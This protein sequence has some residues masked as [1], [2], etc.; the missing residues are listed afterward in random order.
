MQTKFEKDLKRRTWGGD[1]IS[2]KDV[3][4]AKNKA[5]KEILKE[6]AEERLEQGDSFVFPVNDLIDKFKRII[7]EKL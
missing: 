4:K 7:E 5:K 1:D 2:M 3:L 6:I